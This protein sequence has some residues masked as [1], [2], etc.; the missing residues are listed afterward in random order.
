MK[1]FL[2]LKWYFLKLQ[3][4]WFNKDLESFEELLKEA[5]G[6]LHYAYILN[7]IKE[8]KRYI[9]HIENGIKVVNDRIKNL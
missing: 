7:E 6:K 1:F 4:Y 9:K 2:I 5:E 3:L 8:T